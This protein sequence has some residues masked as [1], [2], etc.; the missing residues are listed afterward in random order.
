MSYL[1]KYNLTPEFFSSCFLIVQLNYVLDRQ[2]QLG[3]D[4][5]VPECRTIVSRDT[6]RDASAIGIT[7]IGFVRILINRPQ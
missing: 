1:E 2:Y 5:Q 3:R 7:K 4:Q 6:R